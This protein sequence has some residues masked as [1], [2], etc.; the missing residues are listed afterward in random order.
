M[1]LFAL[2]LIACSDPSWEPDATEPLATA[3]QEGS[4]EPGDDDPTGETEPDDETTD[5]PGDE[6]E[7]D[8]PW[9]PLPALAPLGERRC[10]G[11]AAAATHD[12]GGW[13]PHPV[14]VR[15][16]QLTDPLRPDRTL[17][18]EIWYP[19][20]ESARGMP[21]VSYGLGLDDVAA[22]AG[23]D[24]GL[25][26]ALIALIFGDEDLLTLVETSAVRDAALATADPDRGLVLFSHGYRGVR[27]QSTFLTT[28]L[29]SHGYVVAAPDHVGNTMFDGSMSDDDAVQHRVQ[30]MAFL[31]EALGAAVRDSA[32]VFHQAWDPERVGWVGHS[33]GA[34]TV[35]MA[36]A[37]DNQEWVGVSLAPL[38]DDRMAGV[39]EPDQYE[40]RGAL[41]VLGGTED[42]TC[43][44]SH[45]QDAYDHTAA[46]RFL[47]QLDGARHF[48]FTDLCANDLFRLGITSFVEE[49]NDACGADP[50]AYH[51]TVQALSTATLN[52]YLA[53]DPD[54]AADLV[55][56]TADHL[57][58]WWADPAGDISETVEPL[59]LPWTT[60]P[61]SAVETWAVDAGSTEVLA[62]VYGSGEPLV[63]VP[64]AGFDTAL[65]WSQVDALAAEHTVVLV[66][67]PDSGAVAAVIEALGLVEPVVIGWGAGGQA[68]LDL[69]T[70]LDLAGAVVTGTAPSTTVSWAERPDYNG[71]WTLAH[72]RHLALA[73]AEG[74]TAA[75]SDRLA[76][77]GH[78]DHL[79]WLDDHFLP[80]S[81]P[82]PDL[83]DELGDIPIPVLIIHG[84]QDDTVLLESGRYLA[85]TV[86]DAELQVFQR[87]G[88]LPFAEEPEAFSAAV[89]GWLA[90][91]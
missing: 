47:G 86:P 64:D 84:E 55:S 27:Y 40:V 66:E 61:E 1:T 2:S 39:T 41:T 3:T 34:S 74:W 11:K 77:G 23:D 75:L 53:C 52:R 9:E 76:Q 58:G 4:T 17:T 24:Y 72:A 56:P 57:V 21:G 35:L 18:T 51:A 33:F 6:P 87:S 71:G 88:N 49:L 8:D 82:E 46:P 67:S 37:M 83:L 68:A 79:A 42:T 13:G 30:D 54:A 10:D 12:P 50:T 22:M 60:E 80:V 89:L 44:W 14:G 90:T 59:A 15:T 38:F 85:E 91:L 29:A 43:E 73:S 32:D 36:G 81:Q 70:R 5:D 20:D 63:L 25:Y 26:V 7:L 48:D 31:S 45:Q 19:A 28:Y 78:P 16:I 65:W 69:A 62:H